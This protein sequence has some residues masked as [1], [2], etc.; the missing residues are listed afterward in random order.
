MFFYISG[1][2]T[3]YFFKELP[4]ANKKSRVFPL[5]FDFLYTIFKSRAFL[6]AYIL[7]VY[8]TET[9]RGGMTGRESDVWV[10][11]SLNPDNTVLSMIYQPIQQL[12]YLVCTELTGEAQILCPQYICTF[13][14]LY[15]GLGQVV[16]LNF[17]SSSCKLE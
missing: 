10:M 17:S 11:I 6:S 12:L 9:P 5:C 14:V 4:T 7:N 8:Q 13:S 2:Y 1:Q 3:L 15:S 16:S